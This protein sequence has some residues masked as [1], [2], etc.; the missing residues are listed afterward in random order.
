MA[1][2]LTRTTALSKKDGAKSVLK[3]ADVAIKAG[4]S[5]TPV[6]GAIYEASKIGLEVARDYVQ[7]RNEKRIVEF[8]RT[9]LSREGVFDQDLIDAEL[10]AADFHALLDACVSDIEEE[11]TTPYAMLTR[12][13]ALGLVPVTHRRHFIHSLK[14]LAFEHLDILRETYTMTRYSC[15]SESGKLIDSRNFLTH[16]QSDSISQLALQTLMARGLITE[17]K[18]TPLGVSFIESC[19][20]SDDLAPY[21]FNYKTAKQER[22][23]IIKLIDSKEVKLIESSL[24]HE[25]KRRNIQTETSHGLRFDGATSDDPLIKFADYAFVIALR[26]SG[27]SQGVSDTLN[28][29]LSGKK[30]LQIFLNDPQIREAEPVS[31]MDA[32]SKI[33]REESPALAAAEAV[34][35]I[36]S[37]K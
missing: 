32:P 7:G 4:F 8:H 24:I 1:N 15:I 26:H 37:L 14:E 13:I 9:L 25:L 28:S 6:G 19:Y 10:N 35:F 34:E 11:K 29:S 33:I 5:F 20:S 23:V 12:S 18:I 3:I 21:N 30:S 36:L 22:G 31:F 17:R 16:L 2:F 27:F